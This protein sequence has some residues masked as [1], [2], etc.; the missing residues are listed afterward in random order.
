MLTQTQLVVV[1]ELDVDIGED[2]N[3]LLQTL[4]LFK[5]VEAH[6]PV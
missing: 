1:L 5:I 3:D 2:L 4:L 6:D